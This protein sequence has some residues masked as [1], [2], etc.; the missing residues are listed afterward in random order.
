MAPTAEVH[1]RRLEQASPFDALREK[2]LDPEV[3]RLIEKIEKR[4]HH[5]HL[6]II[7]R[8]GG[9]PKPPQTELPPKESDAQQN[10]EIKGK[11]QE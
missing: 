3:T 4:T 9:Q 1:G 2:M 11:P 5:T 7:R 10:P 8:E 6:M